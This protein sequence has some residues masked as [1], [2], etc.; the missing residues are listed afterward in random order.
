[1]RAEAMRS[2]AAGIRRDA[3]AMRAVTLEQ[4]LECER[5][6]VRVRVMKDDN[7]AL[8]ARLRRAPRL[9]R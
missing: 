9:A 3:A 2:D 6:R 8:R 4:R 7:D 5:Q 1:M